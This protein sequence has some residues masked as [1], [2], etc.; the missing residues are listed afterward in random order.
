MRGRR[1][2]R[3]KRRDVFGGDE[4]V[5]SEWVGEEEEMAGEGQSA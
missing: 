4:G 2:I 5:V 1:K 3:K